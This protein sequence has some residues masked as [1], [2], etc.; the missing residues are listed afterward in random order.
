MDKSSTST[1]ANIERFNSM[2]ASWDDDPVRTETPRAVASAILARIP[3]TGRE[4]AMEFGSGTG[5]V[6]GLLAPHVG[7]VTAVDSSAG[8]LAVLRRKIREFGLRNVTPVEADLAQALPRGPFDL[9]FSSMTLHHI[10]DV[11]GLFV[12][13]F[14]GLVPGGCVALADLEKEDGQ[15]HGA[16]VPGVMH[17]GFERAEIADWLRT[18]GFVDI[19]I[20]TVHTVH[21]TRPDGSTGEYPVFLATARRPLA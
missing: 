10:G 20:E 11:A 3:L 13:M 12:R 5:L 19:A 4:Q 16:D 6:T 8:M 21:K 1:Q 18:A 9:V 15:F 7:H 17:H 2:A 14:G